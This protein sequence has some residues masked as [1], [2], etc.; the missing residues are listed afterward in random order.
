L[1]LIALSIAVKGAGKAE[2]HFR[3]M[4]VLCI[5][6]AFPLMY[7]GDTV[8]AVTPF[9]VEYIFPL[10]AFQRVPARFVMFALLFL[11]IVAGM[12]LSRL[13]ALKRKEWLVLLLA[14]VIVIEH[15]P[16]M[17]PL[18]VEV[19]QFYALL[20]QSGADAALFLYPDNNYYTLVREE[21]LQTL[22]GKKMSY[23]AVSRFPEGNELFMLYL[24]DTAGPQDAIALL[25]MPQYRYDYVVVHKGACTTAEDC[26]QSRAPPVDAEK[27]AGIRS[28]LGREYGSPAYEDGTIIVYRIGKLR[29]IIAGQS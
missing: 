25:R 1:L 19:P 27:L 10:L 2:A 3:D 16:R 21:Y 9:F 28:A 17:E 26:F 20:S 22:H 12:L 23:G 18:Q 11:S 6:F 29:N 13:P 15:W 24:N 5:L 7:V 4:L 14:A 8:V